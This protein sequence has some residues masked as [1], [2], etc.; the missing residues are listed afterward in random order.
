MRWF[1]K[2]GNRKR[3]KGKREGWA[4][5]GEKEKKRCA[6]LAAASNEIGRFVLLGT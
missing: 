6:W 1:K 3:E 5:K 4:K 2:K